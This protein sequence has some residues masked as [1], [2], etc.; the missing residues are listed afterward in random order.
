MDVVDQSDATWEHIQMDL[1][2]TLSLACAVEKV[3]ASTYAS[4]KSAVEGLTRGLA[5]EFAPRG[6]RVSCIAPDPTNTPML[7]SA[8]SEVIDRVKSSTLLGRIC[9]PEEVARVALFFGGSNASFM[10]GSTV[11]VD[12]GASIT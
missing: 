12:G 4:T 3:P 10:T 11:M 6:T 7:M 8:S 1:R 2:D 9:E 5:R